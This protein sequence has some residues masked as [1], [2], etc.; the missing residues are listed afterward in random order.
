MV[1]FGGD[2]MRQYDKI[3]VF[4]P[5]PKQAL[6]LIQRLEKVAQREDRSVNHQV[7]AAIEEY[8]KNHEEA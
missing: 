7:V 3:S 6:K 2:A 4:I 8:L 5:K 1:V